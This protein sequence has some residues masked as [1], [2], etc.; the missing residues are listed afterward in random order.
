MP[1]LKSKSRL[2]HESRHEFESRLEHESR[3]DVESRHERESR[4][5]FKSRYERE[6]RRARELTDALLAP[7]PRTQTWS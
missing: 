4:Y 3:Y 5:E 7:A 1:D 2:E 6:S